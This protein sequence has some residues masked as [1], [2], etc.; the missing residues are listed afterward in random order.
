[1][2]ALVAFGATTGLYAIL[3]VIMNGYVI[4]FI[5]DG[6][7]IIKRVEIISRKS[8][9]VQKF[10]LN[11]LERS[12]TIYRAVGAYDQN[13]K[14]VIVTVMGKKEFLKLR[15]FLK[16]ND[17][18]AFIITHNVHEVLGEGFNSIIE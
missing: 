6:F 10:I 3:G 4:D 14:D 16:T 5:I 15:S 13:E 8:N 11:E 1:M 9:E 17:P 2:M 12:A 18:E 7:N